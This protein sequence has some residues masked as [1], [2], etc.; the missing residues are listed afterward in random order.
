METVRYNSNGTNPWVAN[1]NQYAGIGKGLAL[2]ADMSLYGVGIYY[3][4][5]IKYSQSNLHTG[6]VSSGIPVKF[7]LEQNYP[8]PFNPV[9][10]IKF[11]IPTSLFTKLSIYDMTGREI[12]VLKNEFLTAGSHNVEWNALGYSSGI[13]F[14]KVSTE[15]FSETKK[16]ILIK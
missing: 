9:T 13:Y 1:I 16:M 6:V 12:A 10:K 3:Y 7:N 14:Y 5:V 8:N 2:G 4:S 11:D 15:K